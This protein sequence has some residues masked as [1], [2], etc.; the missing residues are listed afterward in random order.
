[1]RERKVMDEKD[2]IGVET[3]MRSLTH[4]I[5]YLASNWIILLVLAFSRIL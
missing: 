1:M 4:S 3:W 5:I 2:I